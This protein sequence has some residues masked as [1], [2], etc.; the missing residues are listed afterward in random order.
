MTKNTAHI[1]CDATRGYRL[2]ETNDR[3]EASLHHRYY[4]GSARSDERA[5]ADRALSKTSF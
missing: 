1:I 4:G 2:S 3:H 5:V